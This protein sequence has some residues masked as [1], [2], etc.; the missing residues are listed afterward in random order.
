MKDGYPHHFSSW[1]S[2]LHRQTLWAFHLG[3]WL[4]FIGY[5]LSMVWF[6]AGKLEP[7]GLYVIYYGY[8]IAFFYLNVWLLNRYF[9]GIRM[10]WFK[11]LCCWLLL[12]AADFAGKAVVDHIVYGFYH[13]LLTGRAYIFRFPPSNVYRCLYFAM[14]ALFYWTAGYLKIYRARALASEKRQLTLQKQKAEADRDLAESRNAFLQQQISPHLLFN[15]LNFL[16]STVYPC[17]EEGADCIMRLADLLRFGLECNG[18]EGKTA[19]EEELLQLENLLTINRYRY[20]YPV[21]LQLETKGNFDQCRI[22]PLILLTLTENVIKHGNLKDESMPGHILI[23][24]S[25][26]RLLTY[27][28]INRK[29]S[30]SDNRQRHQLGLN[31]IRTR[32]DFAY[33]GGY[34]LAINESGDRYELTLKLSL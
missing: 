31:N 14:L 22:I 32:L 25:P 21:Y 30:T 5:E 1:G 16:Y 9:G 24:V 12:F 7:C 10:M 2:E 15:T 28:S 23:E 17:S 20:D 8:N 11:G 18:P 3:G 26:D 19:I 13:P 4:L 33:H 34:S 29:K 27:R 6:S